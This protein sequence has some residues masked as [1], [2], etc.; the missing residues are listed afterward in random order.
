MTDELVSDMQRAA[1]TAREFV[2]QL[3]APTLHKRLNKMAELLDKG[4]ARIHALEAAK[5]LYVFR[6]ESNN[7]AVD[8]MCPNCVTPWK[9]NGPHIAESNAGESEGKTCNPTASN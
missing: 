8:Y 1:A 4:A 3:D 9:C 7:H 6:Q 2:R 5:A